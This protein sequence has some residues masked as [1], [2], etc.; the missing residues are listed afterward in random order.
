[1]HRKLQRLALV[2]VL[3]TVSCLAQSQSSCQWIGSRVLKGVWIENNAGLVLTPTQPFDSAGVGCA[4]LDKAFIPFS[5]PNFKEL[6]AA[7]LS[8]MAS[9][10]PV[11]GYSC[12]C[13]GW[14]GSTYLNVV[15]LGVGSLF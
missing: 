4:T 8:A 13:F 1:M 12:S 10:T 5:H 6:Y 15:S 9:G 14:W 11:N 3:V 2:A 7:A